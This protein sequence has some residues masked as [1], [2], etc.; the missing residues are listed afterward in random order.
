[1]INL[2]PIKDKIVVKRLD[3]EVL[4]TLIHVENKDVPAWG[5]VIATGPGKWEN[6]AQIPMQVK[7]G[8]KIVFGKYCGH[9][10]EAEKQQFLVLVEDDILAICK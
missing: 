10:V 7:A 3:A 2:I 1:M 6:G 8:D 5:Y 9:E 4:S